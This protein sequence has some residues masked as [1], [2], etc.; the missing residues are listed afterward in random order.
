MNSSELLSF[1]R[2][3]ELL[4]NKIQIQDRLNSLNKICSGMQDTEEPFANIDKIYKQLDSIEKTLQEYEKNL[5]IDD[6]LIINEIE[7]RS[8]FTKNLHKW[9]E[10]ILKNKDMDN[11]AIAQ[12]ISSITN[13]RNLFIKNFKHIQN[14]LDT[15][16]IEEKQINYDTIEISFLIPRNIFSS[17]LKS[18]SNEIKNIDFIIRTINE[19][20]NG[21][22]IEINLGEIS[23][24]TPT[25]NV[26]L[27]EGKTVKSL[28]IISIL[29]TIIG[30]CISIHKDIIEINKIKENI[31][32]SDFIDLMSQNMDEKIS[33]IIKTKIDIM[34][35]EIMKEKINKNGREKEIEIALNKT[36]SAIYSRIERGME[37]YAK[38]PQ[39]TMESDGEETFDK[40][41]K[42]EEQRKMINYPKLTSN[43]LLLTYCENK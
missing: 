1:T 10:S 37:I 40:A 16:G 23:C 39:I 21:D 34:T 20:I 4:E 42:I 15:I 6:I 7:K 35:I 3:I 25:I 2:R 24:S 28:A 5:E 14:S 36:I 26:H 29:L 9:L 8:F 31:K 27:I 41:R 32:D 43:N 19:A 11:K 33:K 12:L 18:F 13:N 17:N 22:N 30:Q 38:I